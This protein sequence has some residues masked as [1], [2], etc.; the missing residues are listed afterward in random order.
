MQVFL[1]ENAGLVI[2][3]MNELMNKHLITFAFLIVAFA[4]YFV[5]MA[6]P[7]A[8][9]MLLGAMAEMVVWV[10]LFRIGRGKK[11]SR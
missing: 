8:I 11:S 3:G 7:A 4:F 2:M 6:M 1:F 5:G 10:R 9:F